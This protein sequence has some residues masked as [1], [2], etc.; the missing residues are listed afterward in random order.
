MNDNSQEAAYRQQLDW[1]LSE[2]VGGE[3][4]PDVTRQVL[5]AVRQSDAQSGM[6]AA[7]SRWLLCAAAIVLGVVALFGVNHL[8]G[9]KADPGQTTS[10]KLDQDP[11]A[12]IVRAAEDVAKLPVDTRWVEV[13]G[14]GDAIVQA[15][16]KRCPKLE[17]L[18]V[19]TL[20]DKSSSPT[21]QVFEIAASLSHLR[22]LQLVKAVAVTGK[23]LEKLSAIPQLE[24]LAIG[25]GRLT[26]EAFEALPRLPSLRILDLSYTQGVDDD[27]LRAIAKCP[28]LRQLG[29]PGCKDVTAVGLAHLSQ[30]V[31]IEILEIRQLKCSLDQLLIDRMARL[32]VLDAANSDVSKTFIDRLP[33]SLTELT[34]PADDA[35][36]GVIGQR[37]PLLRRLR[38]AASSVTDVG[39]AELA[40]LTDLRE[41]DIS[42][43]LDV[44]HA[45]LAAFLK[46]E[47]LCSLRIGR[48]PGLRPEHVEPLLAI[49]IDIIYGN[50]A[51][52]RRAG[53][54]ARDI[55]KLRERHTKAIMA[56]RARVE[57]L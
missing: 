30:L 33:P 22:S 28:G 25:F 55:S 52:Q 42:N 19:N 14:H 40:A 45:G 47:R 23:G 9:S 38:I 13:V 51:V 21:D 7:R 1:G 18:H 50:R 43:C 16:A 20:S 56:R 35:T 44:T 37:L 4:S 49:G 34:L 15:I 39:V 5:A 10:K 53:S 3:T 32:R 36:C 11:E 17:K 29:I 26:P 24:T 41:L 6:R 31:R 46:S 27:A 57:K 48:T 2:V 8:S 54:I 12:H